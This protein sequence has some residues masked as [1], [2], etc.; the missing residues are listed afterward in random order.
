LGYILKLISH[1]VSRV[2]AAGAPTPG[3]HQG[4]WGRKESLEEPLTW[5]PGP[6]YEVW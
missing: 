2:S 6:A 4:W 5:E 3:P 1:L